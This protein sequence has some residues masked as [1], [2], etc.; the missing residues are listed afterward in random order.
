MENQINITPEIKAYIE[1]A[2]LPAYENFDRGHGVQHVAEVIQ[3]SF[4]IVASGK[5]R[6]DLDMVYVVAAFHD[7]GMKVARENHA[8]HSARLLR[9]D[10]T[11]RKWFSDEQIEIM[12]AAVVDHSTSRNAEPRS[13]YGK[14][15]CDA[16]KD[17]DIETSLRRALEFSFATF[18]DFSLEQHLQSCY[19]HLQLKFGEHGLVKFYVPCSIND[20]FLREIKNLAANKDAAV[21]RFREVAKTLKFD[22]NKINCS[23][24]IYRERGMINNY[25]RP[26]L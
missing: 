1:T 13:I 7:Y 22:F 16:D 20:D 18:K 25:F 6:C 12:A 3:R 24:A 11:L 5:I 9:N 2:I 14:I 23:F 17:T 21:A 19:E 15:V 4:A 8:E 26:R 10:V